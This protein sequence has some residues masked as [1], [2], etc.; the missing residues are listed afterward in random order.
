MESI[1]NNKLH[2]K[3][4]PLTWKKHHNL[5]LTFNIKKIYLIVFISSLTFQLDHTYFCIGLKYPMVALL[6]IP[7]PT[8]LVKLVSETFSSISNVGC[9]SR[10]SPFKE[11]R[12]MAFLSASQGLGREVWKRVL[13]NAPTFTSPSS[14]A[15]FLN[16]IL[17]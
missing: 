10:C 3:C 8:L 9:L 7:T 12:S 15:K 1:F 16:E 13:K 6:C 11:E 14:P 2:F 5:F 17:N 4:Q